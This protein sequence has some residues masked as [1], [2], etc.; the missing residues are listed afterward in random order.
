MK[1]RKLKSKD[2]SFCVVVEKDQS[3]YGPFENHLEAI[4]WV[5]KTFK[6]RWN[7]VKDTFKAIAVEKVN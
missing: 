3:A 4:D 1:K 6:V 5:E 2:S 7:M